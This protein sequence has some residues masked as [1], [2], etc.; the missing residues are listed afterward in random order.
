MKSMK[1]TPLSLKLAAVLLCL[2]MLSTHFT[3]GMYARYVT[4]A[5]GSDRA[6]IA[7]FVVSAVE[8]P[9]EDGETPVKIVSEGVDAG[10]ATYSLLLTNP[11]QTAVA[12]EAVVEF[13]DEEGKIAKAFAPTAEDEKALTFSGELSPGG[14]STET[15]TFDL[16]AYFSTLNSGFDFSNDEMQVEEGEIQFRVIV[17]FTQID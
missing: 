15:V 11:G 6:R 2:V 12:Y 7:H 3:S 8:A 4:R 14:T 9:S 17:T 5:N 13:V 1:K 16:P 10:K